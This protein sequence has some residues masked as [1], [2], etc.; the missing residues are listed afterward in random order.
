MVITYIF[1]GEVLKIVLRLEENEDEYECK[2][3]KIIIVETFSPN[4]SSNKLK[5]RNRKRFCLNE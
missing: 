3:K 2:L 1:M 5:D 4:S